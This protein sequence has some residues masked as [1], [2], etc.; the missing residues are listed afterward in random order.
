MPLNH[1]GSI[2][3]CNKYSLHIH[4]WEE[5]YHC[6]KSSGMQPFQ[7]FR[8]LLI[9]MFKSCFSPCVLASPVLKQLGK[10]IFLIQLSFIQLW[11]IL[12]RQSLMCFSKGTDGLGLCLV[13]DQITL[14]GVPASWN[15]FDFFSLYRHGSSWMEL[16]WKPSTRNPK[17][18]WSWDT[19]N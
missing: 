10:Q 15:M 11:L 17:N 16:S 13:F 7:H 14:L 19:V 18:C 8:E 12:R 4:S 9:L 3:I 1:I 5:S 2:C 6:V